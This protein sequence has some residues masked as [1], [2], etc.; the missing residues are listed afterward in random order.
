IQSAAER[1]DHGVGAYRQ[2]LGGGSW[3]RLGSDGA[4]V[5]LLRARGIEVEPL[6][7]SNCGFEID[8]WSELFRDKFSGA[9]VKPVA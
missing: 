1:Q 3:Q 6:R 9:P 5:P 7:P 2:A 8:G 4:W